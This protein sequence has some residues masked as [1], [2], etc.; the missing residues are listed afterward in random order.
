MGGPLGTLGRM[1][2]LAAAL[3]GFAARVAELDPHLEPAAVVVRVGEESIPL[4][5]SAVSA[6]AGLLDGYQDPRANGDCD[7]CGG[8]RVDRNFICLDCGHAN[9]VF[10]Q[11]IREHSSRWPG[12][13]DELPSS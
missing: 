1:D 7:G 5:A 6:L 8:R 11:L 9:G 2:T 3:R 13:P 12:D 4:T 10:G